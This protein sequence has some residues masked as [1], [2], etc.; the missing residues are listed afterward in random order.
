MSP[1]YYRN[2]LIRFWWV[3]L[4]CSVCAGLGGWVGGVLLFTVY[5][6]TALIQVEVRN[7]TPNPA[8]LLLVDRLTHTGAKLAV[9]DNILT[10]VARSHNMTLSKLHSE[11]TANP[12]ANT[13]LV[14]ITVRDASSNRAASLANEIAQAVVADQNGGIEQANAQS[15]QAYLSTL[16]TLKS[17]IDDLKSKLAALGQPPSDPAQAQSLQAQIVAAQSQ[18]DLTEITLIRI[19]AILA[20]ETSI[21]R[22]SSPAKPSDRPLISHQVM[23]ALAGIGFGLSFG[24]F[25]VIGGEWT[26][27]QVQGPDGVADAF[28]WVRIGMTPAERESH[29]L[30]S[31]SDSP[32]DI[33]DALTHD[34]A[35]LGLERPLRVIALVSANPSA[36]TMDIAARLASAYARSNRNTL[37]IDAHLREGLQGDAFGVPSK[38]GLSD[39]ILRLSNAQL[40]PPEIM[41]YLHSPVR[42]PNPFLLIVPSGSRP[43]NA[44]RLLAS[45]Q[46]KRAITALVNL[47]A[48]VVLL[49]T[50]AALFSGAAVS[51][52]R[53][54]DGVLILVDPAT[55]RR[56]DIARLARALDECETPVLGFVYSDQSSAKIGASV[57]SSNFVP[58]EQLVER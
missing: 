42:N 10:Q 46:C 44:D 25:L 23:T 2:R 52:S 21:M 11:V 43:P 7:T 6:S 48:E 4:L 45:E 9:S 39:I 18:Y 15:Q 8:A 49:D 27:S 12:V 37:L 41:K 38:P 34:I 24:V 40:T 50:P 36:R 29:S 35:F 19:R 33:V 5:S 20:T 56:G 28:Q 51:L 47:P 54:L 31:K 55:A 17:N 30:T 1:R 3:L 58:E 14:A 57:T 16:S 13:Q 26:N 32:L 53:T 22:V